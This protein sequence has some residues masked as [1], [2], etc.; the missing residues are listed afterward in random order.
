MKKIILILIMIFTLS[1]CEDLGE[2]QDNQDVPIIRDD[3]PCINEELP[4]D[5]EEPDPNKTQEEILQDAIDNVLEGMQTENGFEV[6]A[7]S[8]VEILYEGSNY[9]V[10]ASHV[11]LDIQMERE[12]QYYLESLYTRTQDSEMNYNNFLVA[13]L[14]D[15]R[16][17][18]LLEYAIED[19][20]VEILNRVD[21]QTFFEYVEEESISF[22][23][24]FKVED[25]DTLT[26]ETD[27]DYKATILL[28]DLGDQDLLDTLNELGFS[29]LENEMVTLDIHV[30]EVF[31]RYM[32]TIESKVLIEDVTFDLVIESKVE[33][34]YTDYVYEKI[35][36]HE[37]PYYL[38]L[39]SSKEEI[40][41][42]SS[43]DVMPSMGLNAN[44][45]GWAKFDVQPGIYMFYVSSW[46]HGVEHT[47]YDEQGNEVDLSSRIELTEAQTYY[48]K[49]LSPEDAE[50]NVVFEKLEITDLVVDNSYN[51]SSGTIT[52][53]NEGEYDVSTY[54]LQGTSEVGGVLYIDASMVTSNVYR[55]ELYISGMTVCR[56]TEEDFCYIFVEANQDVFIEIR[57]EDVGTFTFDY[58]F[59]E[60]IEYASDIESMYTFDDF[61]E[62]YIHHIK[63][64][65][66]I[67]IKFDIL[68]YDEYYFRINQ[69][70][71]YS[72]L[73][74]LELYTE[75][76][77]LVEMNYRDKYDL[78][79]GT[80]Y[81][82]ISTNQTNVV[83]QI[84]LKQE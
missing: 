40:I 83:M 28:K 68:L 50:V 42:T 55:D 33:A 41:N 70:Y 8:S 19:T 81:I 56:I 73:Y 57:G 43:N 63:E 59:V 37:Q 16:S 58:Y 66:Y 62:G 7:D 51:L 22:E 27:Y 77:T 67:Y 30:N 24:D 6:E 84:E 23:V 75:D 38:V 13:R 25:F 69:F 45:E 79:R 34:H 15:G 48:I 74:D 36:I 35:S 12:E 64:G 14:I 47:V 60:D 29:D 44:E 2:L 31:I 18:N 49:L 52:G 11:E 26:K 53:Y 32:F 65:E 46:M 39:P 78:S 54:N 72:R 9:A 20:K 82:K 17:G 4:C 80:Y 71:V 61:E 1:G 21:N 3:L 76:G 10:A 5:D